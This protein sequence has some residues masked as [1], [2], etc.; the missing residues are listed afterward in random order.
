MTF[1]VSIQGGG[2]HAGWRRTKPKPKAWTHNCTEGV[3]REL[4]GYH[5]RCPDCKVPRDEAL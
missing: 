4:P 3:T 1:N 2:T 5:V